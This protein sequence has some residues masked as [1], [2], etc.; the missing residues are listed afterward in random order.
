MIYFSG[1]LPG[2]HRSRVSDRPG[3]LNFGRRRL[4]VVG[5]HHSTCFMS[6]FW[7]REFWH[8]QPPGSGAIGLLISASVMVVTLPAMV[9]VIPQ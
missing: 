1:L 9:V 4:T 2:V 8:V 6:S 5:A 7:Y 3:G